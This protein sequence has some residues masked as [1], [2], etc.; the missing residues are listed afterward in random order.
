MV[1]LGELW[2]LNTLDAFPQ[3]LDKWGCCGFTTIRVVSSLQPVE[4]QHDSN[5]VL[6][7][8]ISVGKVIH[9]FELFVNNS[10]A[11]L[12]CSA[13]DF[14]NVLCALAHVCQHLV[15]FLRTFDGGLGVEFGWV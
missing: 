9:G 13:C 10:N 5:H 15:D 12:M 14:L 6:N 4:N 11:S 3:V 8:M 7:A 2:V 1:I